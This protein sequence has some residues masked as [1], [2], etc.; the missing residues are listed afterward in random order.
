LS[1]LERVR[2][3]LPEAWEKFAKLYSPLVFAWARRAGLGD[4]D[5]ADVVQE[6]WAAVTRGFGTFQKD[7]AARTFRGWLWAVTRNKL[8]DYFRDRGGRP[9]AAGGST[10]ALRLQAVPDREPA[11]ETGADEHGLLHR[12]LELIRPDFEDR[13]WRAFW[14]MAVD[15]RSAAEVGEDLGMA[16][17]AVHQARFRVLRRLREELAGLVEVERYTSSF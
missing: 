16:A 11:D 2:A 13:T 3:N 9:A 4:Q 8:R 15:V 1:L 7:E 5:A 14:G 10:A 12:A 17:N 6:V